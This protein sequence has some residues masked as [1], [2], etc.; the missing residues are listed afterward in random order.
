[1]ATRKEQDRLARLLPA[2][3]PRW[4]RIYDDGGESCDRYTVVFTGRYTHKTGGYHFFLGMSGAPY[5]PQ[6]FCQHGESRGAC[7]TNEWGFAPMVGRK[8]HLGRRVEWSH[9]PEDCQRAAMEDYRD[10]WDLPEEPK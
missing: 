1:M 2:G 6:G 7:D 4:V 8:G 5:H 3:V 9:L 10:L